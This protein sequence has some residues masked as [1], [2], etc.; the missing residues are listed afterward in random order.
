MENIVTVYF[1]G[2]C[3][4]C[5]R[6][7]RFQKAQ[8]LGA[9]IS[10]IDLRLTEQGLRQELLNKG[11]EIEKGVVVRISNGFEDLFFQGSEAMGILSNLDGRAT[12]FS[13]L[14]RIMRYPRIARLI[15][16]VLKFGRNLTLFLMRRSPKID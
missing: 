15:Y 9:K 5:T 11:I 10:L 16:P 6:Y 14:L 12:F 3:P 4:F 2:E 1:D 13:I 8:A 7:A